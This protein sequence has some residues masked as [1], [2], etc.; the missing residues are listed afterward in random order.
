MKSLLRVGLA[1][2]LGVAVLIAAFGLVIRQ[3]SFRA[4]EYAGAKMRGEEPAPA[5]WE[6]SS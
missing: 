4:V 2:L 5:E 6:A 3:P 1:V